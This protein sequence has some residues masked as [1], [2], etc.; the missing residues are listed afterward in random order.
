[1]TECYSGRQS[2]GLLSYITGTL[3]ESKANAKPVKVN[4]IHVTIYVNHTAYDK[5]VHFHNCSEVFFVLVLEKI[6]H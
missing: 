3:L 1:M 6:W 5:C 4:A 2:C